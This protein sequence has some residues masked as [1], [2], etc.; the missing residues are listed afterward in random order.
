MEMPPLSSSL[1]EAQDYYRFGFLE[2][3]FPGRS[4]SEGLRLEPIYGVYVLN[5]YLKQHVRAPSASLRSAIATVAHSA[6][7]RMDDHAGALVF[8]YDPDPRYARLYAR[9]YSGLTQAYYA[10]CLQ[11]AGDLLDDSF[12]RKA[13]RR[14]FE[15]LLVPVSEGGVYS[16]TSLGVGIAEVPQKP[17]SWILNGWQSVL[18]SINQYARLTSAPDAAELL[19]TS[20]ESIAAALPLFD[21]S[22]LRN[23][24]YGLSGFVYLRLR[25]AHPV[26]DIADVRLEVPGEGEFPMS[27]SGTSRWQNYLLTQDLREDGAPSGRTV[28]MNVALSRASYPRPNRIKMRLTMPTSTEI[29]VEAHVGRYHPV[30]SSPVKTRWKQLQQHLLA[31]GTHDLTFELP[32][33]EELDLIGYPTNFLKKLNGQF[34][35]VYH[36]VHIKRLYELHT[37]EAIPAF[38][39]WAKT[40]SG[41]ICDWARMPMYRR[42]RVRDYSQGL[43]VVTPEEYCR[44][45]DLSPSS[46]IQ[47]E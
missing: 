43:D 47:T 6:V 20:A 46:S 28:R 27:E 25:T 29:R 26:T 31:E 41:Y 38:E 44:R 17:N 10:V 42:L 40:W 32:W 8:W 9:H 37:I 7:R 30:S 34:T 18:V 4:T 39:Q 33:T 23:S 13:A 1:Q 22:H 3:G 36:S 14:A 11:K 21:H 16:E 19:R 45:N 5:D 15:S 24:R 12:L 35:N 2:D